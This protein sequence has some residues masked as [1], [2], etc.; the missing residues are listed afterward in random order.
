M[1]WSKSVFSSVATDIGFD[2]ETGELLVTW[3]NGRVSAYQGVP[4]DV[5]VQCSN[6]PSVGQ[7]LNSEIKNVYGHR[8]R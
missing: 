6:A 8:Y 5:A 4:E 1:S 3:K 2:D 7:F